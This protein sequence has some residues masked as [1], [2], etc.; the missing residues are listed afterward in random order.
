[1]GYLIGSFCHQNKNMKLNNKKYLAT[2]LKTKILYMS[3]DT[4][5]EEFNAQYTHT[6]S[7]AKYLTKR[8]KLFLIIGG[9]INRVTKMF[10]FKVMT[11]EFN[12]VVVE[13]PLKKLF[14]LIKN[15]ISLFITLI[16]VKKEYE[17]IYERCR[18]G[19]VA[20]LICSRIFRIPLIYELNG[21]LDEEMYEAGNIKNALIQKM[22]TKLLLIQLKSANAIIVQT[23]ELK[24][25]VQKKISINNIFVVE[26]GVDLINI[27]IIKKED[28]SIK[29][30]FVG[31]L[32]K[33]HDLRNVF[34]AITKTTEKFQFYIIGDGDI[35]DDY[36]KQYCKDKRF[37]FIGNIAHKEALKYIFDSNIC[38]ASYSQHYSTFKKYGFYFCPLKL[39][40]YSAAGKPTLMY[41]LSNSF[42]KIFE[43]ANVCIVVNSKEEFIKK[44]RLLIRNKKL[45]EKMGRNAKE[46]ANKFTWEKA[47]KKTEVIL[48][49]AINTN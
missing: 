39:L 29:L 16:R 38:I 36:I 40:E 32:N 43:E 6:F 28:E 31:N 42:T 30:V 37:L 7:L 49:Y 35:K 18:I 26:N 48:K 21:I 2:G 27:P 45:M 17:V 33:S 46:I 15:H 14:K 11:T 41:G 19:M 5:L 10:N 44:L 47:A 13:N 1:M 24:E 4:R 34:D 8:N 22:I 25:I 23:N 20:G 9:N 12:P 3:L